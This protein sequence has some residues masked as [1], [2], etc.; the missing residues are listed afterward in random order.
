M[1]LFVLFLNLIIAV[2]N[3]KKRLTPKIH[4]LYFVIINSVL[5]NNKDKEKLQHRNCSIL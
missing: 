2:F 4:M 1:F 5:F 3:L